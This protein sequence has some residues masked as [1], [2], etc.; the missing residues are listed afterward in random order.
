M[1]D[2]VRLAEAYGCVGLRAERPA[3]VDAVVEQA[4]AVRDRT[5]VVDFRVDPS[6]NCFPMVP[7]GATNDEIVLGPA[8]A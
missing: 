2:Y 6:E 5:V 3:E 8:V 1:Q 4:L 7:A